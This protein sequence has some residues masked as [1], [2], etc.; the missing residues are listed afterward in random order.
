[1]AVGVDG[2]LTHLKIFAG[3]E[4]LGLDVIDRMCS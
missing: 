1:M 2:E 3:I 4:M